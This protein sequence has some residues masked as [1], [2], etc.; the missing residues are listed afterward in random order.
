METI[1]VNLRNWLLEHIE[2]EALPTFDMLKLERTAT[3]DVSIANSCISMWQR[4]QTPFGDYLTNQIRE[5]FSQMT[6][7]EFWLSFYI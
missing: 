2:T 4:S 5:E 6:E 3:D 1:R 7:A